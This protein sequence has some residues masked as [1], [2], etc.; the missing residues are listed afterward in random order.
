MNDVLIHAMNEERI[1]EGMLAEIG[2]YTRKYTFF[3]DLAIAECYGIDAIKDTYNRIMKE[4]IGNRD[5]ICEAL[6]SIN[7]KSWRFAEEPD[8]QDL[9]EFYSELYYKALDEVVK[10]YE[11]ND[12]NDD[13]AYI[14]GVLD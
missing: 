13:L 4:W 14:F 6:I 5:A 7:Y 11:E 1:F 3:S 9:V 10:Y 12:R 8:K 2:G